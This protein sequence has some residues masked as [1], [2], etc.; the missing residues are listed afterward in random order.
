M[1]LL[2]PV[3]GLVPFAFEYISGVAD[4][5]NYLPMIGMCA[6]LMPLWSRIQNPRMAGAFALILI[7]AWTAVTGARFPVW[8]SDEAFFTDMAKVAPDSYN[9]AIGMSVVMCDD[10]KNYDEGLRWVDKALAM[11]SDDI[12]AIANRAFCLTHA[13]RMHDVTEMEFYLGKINY[14]LLAAEQPT[15][16]SSF[17]ASLGSAFITE[18]RLEDGFQFLCEAYQVKPSEPNHARNLQ[19]GAQ[20]LRKAGLTPTCTPQATPSDNVQ[21]LMQPEG[22]EN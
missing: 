18:G 22:G 10:T 17:L 20:I 11:H 5:Y 1:L 7:C 12:L 19:A 3:S 15:A 9:T 21:D 4:H 6:L 2:L 8:S 16:L 13:G 14:E